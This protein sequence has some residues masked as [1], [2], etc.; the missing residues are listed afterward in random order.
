MALWFV[1]QS[2]DWRD[3][4]KRSNIMIGS[5]ESTPCTVIKT[6]QINSKEIERPGS[7]F[8][9]QDMEELWSWLNFEW[10]QKQLFCVKRQYLLTFFFVFFLVSSLVFKTQDG[11]S[12]GK[13]KTF[14]NTC[15][16]L[17][18]FHGCCLSVSCT[19]KCIQVKLWLSKS[20]TR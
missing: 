11:L 10:I 20:Y 2:I 14:T 6:K 7:S 15:L 16:I 3:K 12:C 19:T 1:W 13:G 8:K 9:G 18:L 5:N 4:Q 17:S